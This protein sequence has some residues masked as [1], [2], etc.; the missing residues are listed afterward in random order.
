MV[1]SEV[2]VSPETQLQYRI[3]RMLGEGG[4]GQVFLATR[5]GRSAVVP[6]IVCIK[7]SARIDGWLRE[8]YFGQLLDGHPRAIRVFDTFP[9]VRPGGEVLYCLTLEYA[10]HGDLSAFLSRAGKGWNETTARRE[11]AGILEVLGKLHRGHTLHRDLT[12]L[13]VFVCDGRHLK[14]GDFGIVRQQSD[15]RGITAH[16][17]NALT[18]PSDILAR[19]VPKWQARDDVYQVGQLLGMLIKGDA[20]ARVRTHEIRGL[21]CTDHLKE[22]VYRCLGERRKRYESA[23]EMIEALRNPP[24]ALK[25]GVLRTLKGVHLAFTGILSKRRSV[26]VHAARKAGAIIHGMPSVRTTVVVRGRPNPL[27]AAGRDAGLKLM[28]IK[29]LRK[30]GH[31]ITLLN[32]RQFWKLVTRR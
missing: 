14:L 18:A 28:E 7:V 11:I 30:K 24:A 17:M 19:A 13:N 20:R 4:F 27:Q 15:Q 29:R 23:D 9:L 21:P 16:T 31:R 3:E 26:A 10:R 5:L 12:P 25:V 6:E 22:I 1:P 8:A 32:E 2:V